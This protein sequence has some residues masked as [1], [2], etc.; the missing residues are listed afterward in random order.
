MVNKA[1]VK[2]MIDNLER[3]LGRLFNKELDRIRER[4]ARIENKLNITDG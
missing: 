1:N 3:R 4:I 2:R